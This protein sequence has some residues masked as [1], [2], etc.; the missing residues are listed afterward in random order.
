M[1]VVTPSLPLVISQAMKSDIQP[2]KNER[3]RW[4]WQQGKTNVRP[5]T[6]FIRYYSYY[7][8]KYHTT[9]IYRADYSIQ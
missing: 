3:E 5:K 8:H 4:P 7:T 2:T 9:I 6:T 1:I